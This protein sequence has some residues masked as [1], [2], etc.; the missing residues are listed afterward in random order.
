MNTVVFDVTKVYLALIYI[1]TIFLTF[2]G[3]I[4]VAIFIIVLNLSDF[5]NLKVK[6]T[7]LNKFLK[8]VSLILKKI[9]N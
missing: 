2:I 4:I 6:I 9:K 5:Y 7:D 3:N 8:L 1:L